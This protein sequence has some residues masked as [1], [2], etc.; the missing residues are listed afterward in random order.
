VSFVATKTI[1][2]LLPKVARRGKM[3]TYLWLN[4]MF[5]SSRRSCSGSRPKRAV[6]SV[7]DIAGRAAFGDKIIERF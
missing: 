6:L 5:P 3:E 7:S 1:L 4:F 2:P